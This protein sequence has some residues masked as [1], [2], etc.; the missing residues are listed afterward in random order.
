[1]RD[2]SEG[3]VQVLKKDLLYTCGVLCCLTKSTF[4]LMCVQVTRSIGKNN[5]HGQIHYKVTSNEVSEVTTT[6]HHVDSIANHVDATSTTTL[7]ITMTSHH[8]H[9]HTP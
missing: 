3:S 7:H 8:T 2:R 1:M 4:A 6:S 5:A 9:T